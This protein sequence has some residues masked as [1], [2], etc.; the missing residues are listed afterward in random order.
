MN[1]TYDMT[2]QKKNESNK[3]IIIYFYSK[4]DI[5]L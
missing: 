5:V 2:F 1:S 4:A 3:N